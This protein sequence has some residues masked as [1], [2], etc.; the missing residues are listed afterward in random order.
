MVYEITTFIEAD[1][2][3]EAVN[4]L[5]A[6]PDDFIYMVTDESKGSVIVDPVAAPYLTAEVM[7]ENA[8]EP[9]ARPT[10]GE[11]PRC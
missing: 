9:G 1:S 2:P 7:R 6:Q 4:V 8:Y 3:E 5:T 10:A 11:M